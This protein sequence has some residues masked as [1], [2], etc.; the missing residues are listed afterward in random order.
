MKILQ[1]YYNGEL[2]STHYGTKEDL[3]REAYKLVKTMFTTNPYK[4][5]KDFEIHFEDELLEPSDKDRFSINDAE[6]VVSEEIYL[7]PDKEYIMYDDVEGASDFEDKVDNVMSL[8][9]L[10]SKRDQFPTALRVLFNEMEKAT[11]EFVYKFDNAQE[12][13][14]RFIFDGF[15]TNDWHIVTGRELLELK[16][17]VQ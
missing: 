14:E 12:F 10:P 13:I 17:E 9:C 2:L 5:Y 8:R 11:E 1:Y 15:Y 4:D 16:E 6:A 3:M 7:I